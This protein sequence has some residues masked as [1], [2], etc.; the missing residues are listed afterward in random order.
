M[1]ELWEA[2]EVVTEKA[3]VVGHILEEVSRASSN[4]WSSNPYAYA[5]LQ[6]KLCGKIF[7]ADAYK[8]EHDE[9]NFETL[10]PTV[11]KTIDENGVAITTWSNCYICGAKLSSDAALRRGHCAEYG[12][13]RVSQV[14]PS[15]DNPFKKLHASRHEGN[16]TWPVLSTYLVQ[17]KDGVMACRWIKFK[18]DKCEHFEHTFIPVYGDARICLPRQSFS[19]L[20]V[21][22]GEEGVTPEITMNKD[23]EIAQIKIGKSVS[24]MKGLPAE[25]YPH[26]LGKEQE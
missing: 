20:M 21:L 8:E 3:K 17:V 14:K 25:E 2:I 10:C 15:K 24:L 23:V 1:T 26:N 9:N 12:C 5:K 7:W 18:K 19:D 22:A 6:C 13:H 4:A 11:G 16:H